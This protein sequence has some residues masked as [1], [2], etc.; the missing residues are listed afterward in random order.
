MTSMLAT[1]AARRRAVA[2]SVL[3]SASL[4]LM[5]ISSSPGVIEFQNAMS[6]AL[7]PITGAVHGVAETISG[8]V[9][10]IG[11]IQQLHSDNAALRRDVERLTNDNARAQAIEAENEQLTALLQLR[12]SL[13]FETT[14]AEVIARDSGETRRVVTIS[15]G[16][17]AGIAVGDVVVAE[18]GALVGRVTQAGP[19]AA[20]V[21]LVTD[22]SSTVSG[23]T[24]QS[25]ARGDVV[26]QLGGA[27]IMQ[28]IDST[29]TLRENEQVLTAGIELA[30]GIR[31]P[32]PK[33]LLIGVVTDIR[34][35]ANSVVQTAYLQPTTDLDHLA[36]V[37]V[38]LDYTGGI[39]GP[40]DTPIDCGLTGP[41]GAL[42][43]GE[44]PCIEPSHAAPSPIVP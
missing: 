43:G 2:F 36:F 10:A 34:K 6:F 8:A 18:G 15:K 33:N 14:A 17:D 12:S 16:T 4:V 19:S 37:L 44:Q 31:S 7:R 24:E 38:V 11:E 42:P 3:L 13:A 29:I 9:A 41:G 35:D 25:H 1:R 30:G 5:A 23:E 39:P 27:L 20:A 26:G 22:G 32:Y 40:D 28:N 21:T